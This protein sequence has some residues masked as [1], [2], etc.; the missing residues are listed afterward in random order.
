MDAT[1]REL[2]DQLVADDV[3][4]N[5]IDSSAV[6]KGTSKKSRH[7]IVEI[8]NAEKLGR[9]EKIDLSTG[10]L[11]DMMDDL[12]SLHRPTYGDF[13]LSNS[14]IEEKSGD[15]SGNER[16]LTFQFRVEVVEEL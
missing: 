9:N 10:I 12:C 5:V 1:E 4:I 11:K 14:Q 13:V 8:T 6:N 2:A 3:Q 16:V 7:L 15:S